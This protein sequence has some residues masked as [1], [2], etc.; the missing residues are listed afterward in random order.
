MG[1]YPRSRRDRVIDTYHGVAVADPYRWLE[2]GASAASRAWIAAQQ[3]FARPYFAT[4]EREHLRQRLAELMKVDTL[5]TPIERGG[6]YFY[7]HRAAGSQQGVICRR[8]G[9][10]GAEEVLIDP[11]ALDKSALTSVEVLDVTPDGSLLAYSVRYGGEDEHE[12][13]VMDIASRRTLPDFLPRAR[14]YQTV[15]WRHDRTGFYY[16]IFGAARALIRFHCIGSSSDDD[17]DV[18]ASPPGTF[19]NAQVS[20]DGRYLLITVYFG[21]CAN[22]EIQCKRLDC[23]STAVPIVTGIAAA[24]YAHYGDECLFILTNWNAP[25]WRV[26]R[27]DLDNPSREAWREV[28]P[29]I[30]SPLTTLVAAGGHLVATYLEN[31]HARIRIF[32]PDGADVRD[33][34]LPAEGTADNLVARWSS[35]ELFFSFQSFNLPPTIYR[36]DVRS[37]A[38]TT[39]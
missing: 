11:I 3:E 16:C 29:E 31:V 32:K 30:S 37:G 13:R 35:R 9:L 28:N 34:E 1:E 24:F 10:D 36:C 19:V 7:V 15:S 22:T 12:I 20:D 14:Y 2:D 38:L 23:D 26:M 5:G 4:P 6:W 18:F 8:R 33:I 21:S 17:P 27:I 39:W 25:N